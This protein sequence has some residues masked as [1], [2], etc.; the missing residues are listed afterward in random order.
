MAKAIYAL[1][2]QLYDGNEAV[3]K[4]T[5]HELQSQEL[6]TFQH[7]MKNNFSFCYKLLKSTGRSFLYLMDTV[8][9]LSFHICKYCFPENKHTSN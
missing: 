7:V 9:D 4:M 1:N 2:I 6:N 8:A 3:L 5:P